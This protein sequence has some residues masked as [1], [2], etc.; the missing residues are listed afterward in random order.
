MLFF[1]TYERELIYSFVA[2]IGKVVLFLFHGIFFSG[3]GKSSNPPML[4]DVLVLF[5]RQRAK[6][7]DGTS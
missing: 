3:G 7:G 6:D 1:N 5:L 4:Y 2:L